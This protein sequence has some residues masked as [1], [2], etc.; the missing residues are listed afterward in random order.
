[1]LEKP[2][3]ESFGDFLSGQVKDNPQVNHM[4]KVNFILDFIFHINL[5]KLT[6]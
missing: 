2:T 1:M 3:D 4:M 6:L 5:A